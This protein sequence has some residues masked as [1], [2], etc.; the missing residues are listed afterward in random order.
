MTWIGRNNIVKP[1]ETLV[2]KYSNKV[3]TQLK[4]ITT[5][6]LCKPDKE[7]VIIIQN[8]TDNIE[9]ITVNLNDNPKF[10]NLGV[11]NKLDHSWWK[12]KQYLKKI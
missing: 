5:I 12:W 8:K 2:R 11:I 9:N 10:L 1:S 7:Y 3:L 4:K 6:V